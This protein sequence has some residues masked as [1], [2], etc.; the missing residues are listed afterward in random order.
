MIV[1]PFL[2]GAADADI[3]DWHVNYWREFCDELICVVDRWPD[4]ASAC[5]K[6]GVHYIQ[7]FDLHGRPANNSQGTLHCEG[8]NRQRGL[9]FALSFNPDMI[10]FG[11]CDEVP[12]EAWMMRMHLDHLERSCKIH[13]CNPKLEYIYADWV[14]LWKDERH[15]IGGANGRWSFQN[16]AANKVGFALRPIKGKPYRYRDGLQH[17][18]KEPSPIDESRAVITPER[19][20][21]GHI[22]IL[23]YKFAWWDRWQKNPLSKEAAYSDQL[24]D[25]EIVEIPK[26]WIP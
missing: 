16:P 26:E 3:F 22:K 19:Q 12:A 17:V 7:G 8:Q 5:L 18:R 6:A 21:I 25:A 15:A 13:F 14:N 10:V 2:C 4:G 9:D 1:H 23:H 20:L 11:D 24:A